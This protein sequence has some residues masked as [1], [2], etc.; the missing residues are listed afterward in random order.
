MLP[1]VPE[2]TEITKQSQLKTREMHNPDF[3]GKQRVELEG[4]YE[5]TNSLSTDNMISNLSHCHFLLMTIYCLFFLNFPTLSSMHLLL[6]SI[7][8]ILFP[9]LIESLRFEFGYY[10]EEFYINEC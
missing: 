6:L 7:T 1:F 9:Y 2:R 4:D 10:A 5:M 8:C 3:R